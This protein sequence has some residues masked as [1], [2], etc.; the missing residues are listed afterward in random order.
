M[1]LLSQFFCRLF[2][3]PSS[4]LGLAASLALLA[5]VMVDSLPTSAEEAPAAGAKDSA[6][7]APEREGGFTIQVPQSPA[8]VPIKIGYLRE[9]VEHPR[10]ASRLD[11]EPKDAGIAGAKMAIEENNAGGR[12][13]GHDYS[14][15]VST[16]ASA[17]KA[18]EALKKFYESGHHYIVVDASADTLLKLSDWAKDKDIL[19]FNISA[20]DVSLRQENCRINVMH[21][22]PDRYM[23]ADALA[24]Y[25]VTMKWTN[26]LLVHGST[27]ADLAYADAIKRAAGRFGA[28]IVDVREYKDTSGGRRDDVGT[29][30][31]GKQASDNA[32]FAAN[33]DYQ[34]IMVADEDQVF[35]PYMPYRGGA[36][37]R[38]V[39]G[40]TG[41]IAT[42][43]SRG[44]EKWGATQAHNNFEKDFHRLMLPID[45]QAYVATR[46]V[47]EAVTRNPDADV[48][49]VA[50]F[51]HGPELQLAPFKGIKQQF[52]PWDG[53]F[54][55]PI[56]IA[57]DKVPVSVSPQRGFPHASHPEIEVDTL[58]IDEPESA[59]K[60]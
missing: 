21:I 14:L 48:A 19:L 38:P 45:Y 10:P 47:G 35:G 9:M 2:R 28:T 31:P 26:W 39:A 58:G 42:T 7:A 54:R 43:W 1:Q 8:L 44:H 33:P 16:V 36:D 12:F 5:G 49:T 41:L 40:T 46:A 4:F 50:A 17:E 30:P 51:I 24:Q 11:I 25:L 6:G 53:Q 13:T 34:I 59:C 60:M 29:I 23:L 52:R 32:A 27:P 3:Q 18:V 22:V 55:Q 56:I 20:T 57:T 37:A 15:D